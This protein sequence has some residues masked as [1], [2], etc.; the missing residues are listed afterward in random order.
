MDKLT[1]Y[2]GKAIKYDNIGNPTSVGDDTYTW[3]NGRELAS[4]TIGGKKS[5]YTYDSDGLRASKTANGVTTKYLYDGDQLVYEQRGANDIFYFYNGDGQVT[6]I[7]YNGANYY[8]TFNLKGDIIGGYNSF[9]DLKGSYEYNEWGDIVIYDTCRGIHCISDIPAYAAFN[10]SST[11]SSP[12]EF[13][14]KGN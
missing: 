7:Q 1:S 14:D 11:S 12:K 5:T 8:F 3:Q 10:A 9:G 6:G 4:S 2:N 13:A